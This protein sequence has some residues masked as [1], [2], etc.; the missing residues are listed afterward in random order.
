MKFL[1]KFIADKIWKK[2]FFQLFLLDF[3]KTF[4]DTAT[5]FIQ[6]S[7]HHFKHLF[8]ERCN[9]TS[10]DMMSNFFSEPIFHRS[11]L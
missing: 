3:V 10:L 2:N 5:E 1:C 6:K 4:Q 8:T 7:T 11:S 9:V